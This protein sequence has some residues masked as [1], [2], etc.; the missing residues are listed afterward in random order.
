QRYVGQFYKGHRHGKGICYWS[1]GSKF[2][3]A[4]YLGHVE[5]Y[6]TL[7]W[8]DGRKF[9][10]LYK[11]DER[12]G[13][14][15]ES[16]PGGC[17]DVGLWLRDHLIKL[18]TSVPGYFSV[19]DY[20]AHYRYIDDNSQKKYISIDEDPFLHSYKHLPFDDKDIFPEGIFTYSHNTDHLTL[21]R[22]FLEECD[23]C[24]FQNTPKLPEED[25]WPV[26]NVTPLLVRMQ[27]H[28][29]KHR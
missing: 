21:T 15:I 3:G 11:S 12:F 7:E 24:Y 19:L 27:M 25:P 1:D 26:A 9:Q 5:G 14:G 16:Y 6:G 22:S 17:Q 20:P 28:V 10:G 13:P 2:T 23:A 18:C 8:K 29:Y 4:F